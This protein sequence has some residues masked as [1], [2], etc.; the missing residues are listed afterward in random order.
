MDRTAIAT[1]RHRVQGDTLF[2]IKAIFLVGQYFCASLSHAKLYSLLIMIGKVS[3]DSKTF[4]Q[5]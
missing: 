1:L 3:S 4:L 2:G 5:H